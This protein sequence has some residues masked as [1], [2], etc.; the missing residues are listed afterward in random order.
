MLIDHVGIK[1]RNAAISQKFYMDILGFNLDHKY[2]DDGV[3]LVF[4]KNE[5]FL[6]E[7][8]EKKNT[9]YDNVAAGI[10]EHM[11]FTVPN[12]EDYVARL[13]GEGVE[14]TTDPKPVDNKRV[15]FFKGPD[16]EKLELVQH[17]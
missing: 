2:E 8:I 13:K 4:L 7:I 17:M 3:I 15:I 5:D 12:L 14:F 10:V 1:V 9:S 11:A 16:G 6:L